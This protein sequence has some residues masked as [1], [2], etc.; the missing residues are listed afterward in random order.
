MVT[1]KLSTRIYLNAGLL[2]LLVLASGLLLGFL[3]TDWRASFLEQW[4]RQQKK[5]LESLQRRHLGLVSSRSAENCAVIQ[6]N[7]QGNMENVDRARGKLEK[8]LSS[9]LARY[10]SRLLELNR[11]YTIFALRYWLLSLEIRKICDIPNIPLLYVYSGKGCNDCL[12]QEKILT[13]LKDRD[14][15][16]LLVFA[17]DGDL[18]REDEIGKIKKSYVGATMPPLIIEESKYKRFLTKEKFQTI[19]CKHYSD[20]LPGEC[21]SVRAGL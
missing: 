2:T 1:R 14:G 19:L 7:L 20:V 17:V 12:F 11:E 16:R 10:H 18:L 15:Q 6:T 9:T 21:K 8:Y 4:H 5:D 3:I 13:L